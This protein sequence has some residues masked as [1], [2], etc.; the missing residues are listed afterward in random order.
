MSRWQI[1]FEQHPFQENWRN[2]LEDV[3]QLSVDDQTVVTD[4]QELARLKKV[5]EYLR[6]AIASIDV[7]LVP[8]SIWDSFHGQCS[9]C[10]QEV[11]NYKSNRNIG[12]LHNANQHLDNLLSYVRPYLI[13]PESVIKVLGASAQAYRSQME[14]SVTTFQQQVS[15]ATQ[16]IATDRTTAKNS[17]SAIQ[18]SK[19]AVDAFVTDLIE[20]SDEKKSIKSAIELTKVTIEQQADAIASLHKAMLVDAPDS[21]SIKS[22]VDQASGEVISAEQKIKGLL[23]LTQDDVD[24]L[25]EFHKKIF[26]SIDS[27]GKTTRG[28]KQELDTRFTQLDKL[29]KDQLVKYDAL[30]VKIEKLLPGATSAGLAKAYEVQRRS[31]SIPIKKNTNLFFAAVGLM[32]AIALLTSIQSASLTPL[33]ISFVN[34]ETLEAIAKSMLLKLP[35]MAPLIWLAVF[36]SIRRSQYERLQQEYAHKEALAKSYDSYKKQL[37]ALLTTEK[38]SLQKELINKAVEA[39]AYNASQTLDGKH[40]D[41]MPLEHA[42]DVLSSEKGQSLFDKLRKLLPNR[43]EN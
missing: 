17:M 38:E 43:T 10:R 28:L 21:V 24:D 25:D 37:E 11:A 20:G 13:L 27:E 42:L 19:E 3:P 23:N 6:E 29:E 31:F 16:E 18:T 41:K 15:T 36:A 4:V 9:P 33:S 26:G 22:K 8:K 1:E 2:L 40:R 14:L 35:I 30:F 34:P 7:E 39:I 32:L 12:H 5:V